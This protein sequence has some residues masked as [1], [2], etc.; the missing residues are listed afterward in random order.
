MQ[1]RAAAVYGLVFLLV[2]AAASAYVVTA[3]TPEPT[4]Q[5]ADWNRSEGESFEVTNDAGDTRN[6]SVSGFGTQQG[7]P[8]VTL[9]W[10]DEDVRSTEEWTYAEDPDGTSIVY[11]GTEYYVRS[12]GEA[13]PESFQLLESPSE[14]SAVS[15]F[16][17]G[18]QWVVNDSGDYVALEDYDGLERISVENGSTFAE[19]EEGEVRN[20]T[21]ESVTN[22][23]VTV[24]WT[25]PQENEVLLR[26]TDRE[27]LN[28][29]NVTIH[30]VDESEVHITSDESEIDRYIG[31]HENRQHFQ[32]RVDGLLATTVLSLVAV[33]LLIGLAFLPRKE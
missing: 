7:Q 6:Y 12:T 23:S 16:V 30:V 19:G 8:T 10:T 26:Q 25:Q 17:Q 14:D 33:V 1:G 11:E 18:D 24:S 21:V 4:M 2:A 22:E 29:V 9:V 28:D 13:N 20:V 5:D 15:L 3:D 27:Q 31:A 32:Q